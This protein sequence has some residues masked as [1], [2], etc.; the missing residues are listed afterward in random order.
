MNNIIL[1][2]SSRSTRVVRY[3]LAAI[4]LATGAAQAATF[5]NADG[6]I[7][8]SFDSTVSI[9]TGIRTESPSN[10]LVS[11]TYDSTTFARTGGGI[12]GQFSGLSDQGNINYKEGRPFTTY[13]KG[14]HE[15]LL[16][17]PSEGLSFMARA[18]WAR[19][20]SATHTTGA[21]SGQDFVSAVPPNIQGGLSA[22][23]RRDL[24]FKARLLD[25]WVSKTFDV[26]G[27]QVRVRAGNQVIS[28]GESLYEIGGINAT[29]AIDVNR[30]AQP[31]AQVKEFV[32]PAPMVSVAAGLGGGVNVEGYVQVGWNKSYLPPVGS[33]FSTSV[34]GVGSNAY[35]VTTTRA[36]DSGQWG[37][38]LR[39]QPKGTDL[40]LGA[41]VMNYHDKLPQT[42]LSPEGATI[43]RYP[44]NRRM[45]G[46]SANFP[47]GD[48]AIGTEL[49]YRPKDAVPLNPASGCVAQGGKCWADT[50]RYQWHLTSLLAL[51]PGNAGPILS[52]L[53][54]DTATLTTETVVIGYPNLKSSY[55]GSPIASGG[56]LWGN[57]LNDVVQTG[58]LVTPGSSVGT[59]Y[60]GGIN[61]D[62]NWVYDGSLIKGWQVN[63]GI[64]IRRGL[65][66]RTPGISSQFMKGVTAVNYYVNFIQN[67]ATWQVSANYTRFM[68]GRTLLDNPVRDRDFF[69]IVVSRNF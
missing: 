65:F 43:Y 38:A 50:E 4:A 63:P 27:Q 52:L 2:S 14:T 39:Y 28:W 19:D 57:E 13:L 31:G 7:Q 5:K 47:V 61:V 44:E 62:F 3:Q 64:Y 58:A 48:W 56:L 45:F 10:S 12:M 17:M 41:Y 66:G 24:R 8:G 23:A 1:R 40:N 26:A 60:S 30:A 51:Q 15:L 37:L 9:G 25:L 36:K 35:G 16:K 6:S 68:G 11:P 59:K 33:Y 42:S 55:A 22:D 46:L 29:N 18:A 32:L 20:F 53:K 21:V 34:V 54:A 69:G 49:S 67:P